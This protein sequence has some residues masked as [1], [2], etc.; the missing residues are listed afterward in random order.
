MHRLYSNLKCIGGGALK[1][2]NNASKVWK[3]WIRLDMQNLDFD[4]FQSQNSGYNYWGR[5]NG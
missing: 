4:C 2:N 5:P 1:S 3:Q